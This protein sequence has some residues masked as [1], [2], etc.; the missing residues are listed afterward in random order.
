MIIKISFFLKCCKTYYYYYFI[1]KIAL[2]SEDCAM[3]FHLRIGL[4]RGRRRRSWPCV[5]SWA[6]GHGGT[7]MFVIRIFVTSINGSVNS[8]PSEWKRRRWRVKR[9]G[10]E[11][12][13]CSTSQ[14][15]RIFITRHPY[16][17]SFL[18]S[19][20]PPTSL[21][22]LP[23]PSPLP[24]LIARACTCQGPFSSPFITLQ[25]G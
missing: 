6:T 4:M 1:T 5:R 21:L 17:L 19:P 8:I 2:C 16:H 24:I 10:Q 3:G 13:H 11:L 22:S 15:I 18:S 20:S 25:F 14:Q 9:W 7:V 23:S 12:C